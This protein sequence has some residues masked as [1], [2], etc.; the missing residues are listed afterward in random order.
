MCEVGEWTAITDDF[1]SITRKLSLASLAVS[2]TS[3]RSCDSRC[4]LL[5]QENRWTQKRD[6]TPVSMLDCIMSTKTV[7]YLQSLDNLYRGLKK[8]TGILLSSHGC[9]SLFT[10]QGDFSTIPVR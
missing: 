2:H 7:Y 3:F 10:N 6:P 5:F 9:V 4:S 8:S 1:I